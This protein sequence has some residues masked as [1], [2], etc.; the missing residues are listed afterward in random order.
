MLFSTIVRSIR[1]RPLNIRIVI[2][3][4]KTNPG[5]CIVWKTHSIWIRRLLRTY[6]HDTGGKCKC[7][8]LHGT[9]WNQ[10]D[11]LT[12]INVTQSCA[13]DTPTTEASKSH[14]AQAAIPLTARAPHMSWRTRRIIREISRDLNITA[15]VHPLHSCTR[16]PVTALWYMD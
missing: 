10:N 13:V 1:N 4:L 7:I 15:K 11:K 14:G 12:Y 9:L 6:W 8:T 3:V 5:Y 2:R 16:I